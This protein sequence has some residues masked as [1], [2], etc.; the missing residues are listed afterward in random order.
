MKRVTSGFSQHVLVL[1]AFVGLTIAMTWPLVMHAQ[2]HLINA[3]WYYD[4]MTNIM[5]LGTRIQYILG[6][7]TLDLYENYFCFPVP[8]S[9]VFNENHFGLSLFYLPIY[10]ITGEYLL[11]YNILLILCLTLSGY[12]TWLLVRHLTGSSL[13]GF[14][15]GVGFAFCPYIFFELGRIQLVAAMWVPLSALFLHRTVESGRLRDMV[16]LAICFLMQ[17]GTCLY[18]ALFLLL[19]FAFVGTWLLIVH[20]R[21]GKKFWLQLATVV[22]ISS[23]V[24]GFMVYPYLTTRDDFSLTRSTSKAKRY[25]G[26]VSN[27]LHVY[28]E[29]KTHR[30]LHF[31][32]LDG[33]EQIAFPGFSIAALALL[34][35]AFAMAKA[36][37]RGP[38]KEMRGLITSAVVLSLLIFFSSIGVAVAFGEFLAAVPII[39]GSII[40]WRRRTEKRM[41]PSTI[42]LYGCFVLFAAVLFL[43]IRPMIV[44]DRTIYGI[45]DY[46]YDYVPGFDGI[47]YVSRQII[48][49]MLGLVVLAGFAVADIFRWI[50]PS[51]RR[52]VVFS[53]LTFLILVEFLNAPVSLEKIPIQN[54]LPGSYQWLAKHRGKEPLAIVPGHY[55][56]YFGALHNYYSLY[57]H[58]RT[59][60][61]KSSWIPPI[62]RLYI[63]E[64]RRFPRKSGKYLLDTFGV[65]YLVVQTDELQPDHAS[66]MIA[67]LRKNN[68]LYRP[69]YQSEKDYLFEL[70]KTDKPRPKLLGTTQ[71]L[72]DDAIPLHNWQIFGTAS[73]NSRD[74]QRAFDHDPLTNWNT[75]RVQLSGDWFEYRFKRV[76]KVV[77]IDFKDNEFVLDLPFSFSLSASVAPDGSDEMSWKRLV[78]RPNLALLRDF[79]YR[80]KKARFR[81]VLPEPTPAKRL[82]IELLDAVPGHFWTIAESVIWIKR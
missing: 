81:I 8:F 15:A 71:P 70:L 68:D 14:V 23:A 22:L 61:G 49:V 26:R 47:R 41:L 46:L 10:L 13:A 75:G 12:C 66:R 4:A 31:D 2:T 50:Q 40:Y 48:L 3:K 64:M 57:H 82:R 35:I 69:I 80:P 30:F 27:F 54:T 78:E 17:I 42:A 5:I 16:G 79:V 11:S 59:L 56:G 65:K 29:N 52:V 7:S 20:K 32:S 36:Y 28:P 73:R 55:L 21:F 37:K 19:F 43:G 34:S 38:P 39:V 6:R 67:Y 18:Y 51:G 45:Y 62:T 60:N 9:I 74:A 24:A 44:N 63:H 58:R 1:L 53:G 77:A 25:S 33:S 76:E 72:A